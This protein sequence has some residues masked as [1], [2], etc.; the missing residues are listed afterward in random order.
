MKQWPARIF[1][2]GRKPVVVEKVG[3]GTFGIDHAPHLSEDDIHVS[4]LEWLRLVLPDALVIHVPNGGS[5]D[6]REAVKLKKMGV[7]PG[8][9]DLLVFAANAF[10]FGLEIKTKTGKL[11]AHQHGFQSAMRALGFKVATVRGISEAREALAGWKIS[12]RE[13]K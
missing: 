3:R 13:S 11:S 9:P 10:L 12:T 6:V 2:P 4:V 7:V 1:R 5:R 8:V